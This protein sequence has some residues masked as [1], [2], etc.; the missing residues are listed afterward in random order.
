MKTC[1]S[2]RTPS[3]NTIIMSTTGK[4]CVVTE[5]GTKYN[6]T[7]GP[8]GRWVVLVVMVM[9]VLT[10]PTPATTTTTT[11]TTISTTTA[12]AHQQEDW[13]EYNVY[14]FPLFCDTL[15]VSSRSSPDS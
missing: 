13:G 12:R 14:S 10:H 3:R 6:I 9:M 2:I 1:G 11:T 4:S 7:V 15:K 5:T 8:R